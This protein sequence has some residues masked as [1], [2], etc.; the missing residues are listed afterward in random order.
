V[1]AI[2]RARH[3]L[4]TARAAGV[5]LDA[6]NLQGA[7]AQFYA[8]E[9][10]ERYRARR[11]SAPPRPRLAVASDGVVTMNVSGSIDEA[12]SRR[13]ARSTR[14]AKAGG[15]KAILL[16]VD[17][18][19]GLLPDAKA[20]FD[21]LRGSGLGVVAHVKQA[22]SAASVLAL[23]AD[24]IVLDAAGTFMLH[25][26]WGG[27]G[28]ED[29]RGWDAEVI[30]VYLDRNP[31][32]DAEQLVSYFQNNGDTVIEPPSALASGWCDEVGSSFA[33]RRVAGS[34]ARGAPPFSS[35]RAA[36][37]ARGS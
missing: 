20:M 35:R 36:L 21:A 18:P 13:L 7:A 23:A 14:D 8:S 10:G 3:F 9:I 28:P 12:A 17:S 29:R 26:C 5:K 19:G 33:A 32:T 1:N 27:A 4:A 6:G 24:H 11:A 37:A 15:A 30:Q 22:H 25:R 34:Y 31:C 16:V 2:E